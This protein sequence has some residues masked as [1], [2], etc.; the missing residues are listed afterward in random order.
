M[1][2]S[3]RQKLYLPSAVHSEKDGTHLFFRPEA[4][5]W[6]AVDSAGAQILRWYQEGLA[7]G[8]IIVRY[9]SRNGMDSAKA[10]LHVTDFTQALIRSDFASLAPRL[11]P[12]YL[13]RASTVLSPPN[14]S[15]PRGR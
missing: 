15:V 5:H 2:L 7:M 14:L 12:P 9:G 6:V 13:G 4:P 3:E 11:A 1:P 8:E 10:W